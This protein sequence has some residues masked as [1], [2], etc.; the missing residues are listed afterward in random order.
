M[1]TAISPA[2]LLVNAMSELAGDFDPA[3]SYWDET[4]SHEGVYCHEC[5]TRLFPA[6]IDGGFTWEE[7]SPLFCETC[8]APLDFTFTNHGVEHTLES[9]EE[10]EIKTQ[11]DAYCVLRMMNADGNP[12]LTESCGDWNYH[13]EW[14]VR[15]K[16]IYDRFQTEKGA[17]DG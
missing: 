10:H 15:I 4:G 3:P 2:R 7:D 16:A 9:F 17:D 5:A 8:K 6:T 13:P 14:A 1:T 12:L 11:H